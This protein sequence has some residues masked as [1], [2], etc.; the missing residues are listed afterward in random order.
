MTLF[1]VLEYVVDSQTKAHTSYTQTRNT[2]ERTYLHKQIQIHLYIAN[3]H[4]AYMY[5]QKH[6]THTITQ[7]LK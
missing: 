2:Y 3:T 1:K 7:R 6:T 5:T 4:N